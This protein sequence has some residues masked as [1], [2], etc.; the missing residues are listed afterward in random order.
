MIKISTRFSVGV[1]ILTLLLVICKDYQ[2]ISEFIAGSVNSSPVE[3]RRLIGRLKKTGWS[4]YP[5]A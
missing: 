3:I 1:Y 5:L 4:E 2:C